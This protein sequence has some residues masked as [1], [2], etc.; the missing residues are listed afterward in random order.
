MKG[1]TFQRNGVVSVEDV[2]EPTIL[3]PDDAIVRVSMAG[4]CGS[5]L[6]VLH[7]GEAFGFAP[8]ARL[9][10]EFLGTVEAVGSDVVS[11]AVGDRVLVSVSVNCGECSWCREGLQA[12]CERMSMFGWA[13]RLWQHG[14]DV[15]GGQSEYARVPLANSTLTRIPEAVADPGREGSLLPLID[16]MSTAMH[17]LTAG[18]MQPGFHVVVIG[19]GA[20]GQSAVHCAR[21]LG[22]EAV[23]CLGHHADRL[24][25]AE[26]LGA[27]GV[28]EQRDPEEIREFV[29]G[30]TGG[31]GA[32][33]VVDT[34]SNTS[35][36]QGAH[37]AV[38]PG[39]TIACLGMDHF[40]GK[41]PEINWYDQFVRNIT[42]SG[43]LVHSN[44]YVGPLLELLA[45]DDIDP[46][47]MLTNV[48][49]LDDAAEGYRMMAERDPGVVKV[50]LAVGAT[51]G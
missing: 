15:Q 14:G 25:M 29:F 41:L 31:Q 5:D 20:V 38:R 48:L 24:E 36:M 42:I 26:R 16:V 8:G 10:H 7:A 11:A 6:H 46:A 51:G 47:P 49:S 13:P 30:A 35:S 33:V 45:N 32:H 23:I 44:R 50:A 2:P 43:G 21:A 17:G 40:M 9:G 12:S 34:V 27:S 19:D 28:G 1:L 3:R 4:I 37:A 39:G 22:A 18:R